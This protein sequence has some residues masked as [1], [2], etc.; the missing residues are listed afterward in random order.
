MHS[1][2]YYAGRARYK[3]G[4]K[5]KVYPDNFVA[6]H[7]SVFHLKE[8]IVDVILTSYLGSFGTVIK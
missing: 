5:H 7:N 8:N 3:N 4:N 1:Y 2:S 6:L